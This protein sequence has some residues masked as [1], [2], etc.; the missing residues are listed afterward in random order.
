MKRED[1]TFTMPSMM[2]R[3]CASSSVR[4]VTA[5]SASVTSFAN[6][7]K[8]S[9]SAPLMKKKVLKRRDEIDLVQKIT[10]GQLKKKMVKSKSDLLHFY[11]FNV[12]C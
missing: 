1:V 3:R 2:L 9:T 6:V 5:H 12:E 8:V 11:N 7:M 4:L 10:K